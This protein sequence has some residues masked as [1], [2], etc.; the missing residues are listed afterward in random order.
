[1]CMWHSQ[2]FWYWSVFL[3]D[4]SEEA[5]S[6]V[7]EWTLLSC[8]IPI[9]LNLGSWTPWWVGN[10]RGNASI[11]FN[12]SW[13]VMADCVLTITLT[14]GNAFPVANEFLALTF[15]VPSLLHR[16]PLPVFQI[17]RGLVELSTSG[18]NYWS[19]ALRRVVKPALTL[20]IQF[21]VGI[22]RV[23]ILPQTR[24]KK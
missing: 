1:M 9:T 3:L 6:L 7:Q 12:A 2:G 5:P 18:S 11:R 15:L 23:R 20:V 10:L 24:F 17:S 8:I 4:T 19:K 21:W 14:W 13:C 16:N 22:S